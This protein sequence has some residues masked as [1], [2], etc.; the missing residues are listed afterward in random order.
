MK[1]VADHSSGDQGPRVMLVGHEKQFSGLG[2]LDKHQLWFL[3]KQV[4]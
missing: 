1:E 3:N 4:W 2:G